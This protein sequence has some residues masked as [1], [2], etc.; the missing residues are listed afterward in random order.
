MDSFSA[1]KYEVLKAQC[2]TSFLASVE[3]QKARLIGIT[4][5][6]T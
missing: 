2:H 3:R 6:E 4:F 1:K 5:V